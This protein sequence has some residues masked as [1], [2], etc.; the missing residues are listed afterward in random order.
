[1]KITNHG[2]FAAQPFDTIDS[3][4]GAKADRVAALA[5]RA[6]KDTF[7]AAPA[8][9]W[10]QFAAR[11]NAGVTASD[12]TARS[13][14]VPGRT[15]VSELNPFAANALPTKGRGAGILAEVD[16]KG[17]TLPLG[18]DNATRLAGIRSEVEGQ[19][20]N[21]TG[22]ES[23]PAGADVAVDWRAVNEAIA[24]GVVAG[25]TG[26]AAVSLFTGGAATPT[27]PA[28]AATTGFLAGV[29]TLTVE[30]LKDMRTP[31]K[32]KKP[33]ESK[34][35]TPPAATPPPPT[36]ADAKPAPAPK[37]KEEQDKS[38]SSFDPMRG[39]GRNYEAMR[40]AYLGHADGTAFGARGTN[41]Q[42]GAADSRKTNPG[43]DRE[44]GEGPT[45]E[46]QGP[47]INDFVLVA[48]PARAARV[49]ARVATLAE[50]RITGR[51]IITDPNADG[52]R[53]SGAQPKGNG[54]V[55]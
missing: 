43:R 13:P 2:A 44:G 55:R 5:L 4:R 46:T 35:D 41:T 37:E 6:G 32:S 48:D 8:T 23:G 19:I 38:G 28:A 40:E 47:S 50:G 18:D 24:G 53:P 11:R 17:A 27:I 21:H 26:A 33:D 30:L 25:A 29:A 31:D 7:D 45:G 3:T 15:G 54:L 39:S 10:A 22:P 36:N 52:G 1:M 34:T 9:S 14:A 12:I 42:G 20:G 16:A 51:V 49:D